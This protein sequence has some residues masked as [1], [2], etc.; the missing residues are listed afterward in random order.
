MLPITH[1]YPDLVQALTNNNMVLLQAPPGAGKSTWLPLQLLRD[2]HFTRIV[3]LEPRRIAARTIANYLASCQ[4][5][6]LGQ[7]IGL[8]IRNEVKVSSE[9]RLEIVSE[10]MLTRMLQG[11]PELRGIDC[12]IFDEYHERSLAADT[13][14]ALARQ[15]QA[16]YRDDLTILLMSAT[17]DAKRIQESFQ[18]P[19]VS[20]D[21]R[22]FPID[23]VYQPLADD[24]RWLEGMPALIKRAVTE[25]GGSCLVFLPGQREIDRIS[26][27]LSGLPENIDIYKLYGNQTKTEQQRAI[28]PS[29]SGRRKIVLATNVAETSLTIEGIRVVVDSGRKRLAKF[30][31]NTGVTEL[32]TVKTSLASSV[33]RAGRAGRTEP[34]VVYRVGS[35]ESFLQRESHDL[36]EILSSDISALLLEAKF[37][38]AELEELEF[39]DRPS[40]AQKNQALD[41]LRMLEAIDEQE[42]LTKLGTEILNFGTDIRWAHMLIKARALEN[43][44]PGICYLSVYLLALLDSRVATKAELSTAIQIQFN[45]PHPIFRQQLSYWFKRLNVSGRGEPKVEYLSLLLA[46]AY[47]DRIAKRR[48]EGYLLA[49]GAGVDAREDYWLNDEF[50][51]IAEL[52]GPKG[53]RIFSGTSIVVSELEEVFPYLFSKKAVCEF[54]ERKGRFIQESRLL[55]GAITVTAKTSQNTLSDTERVSAWLAYIR[56]KGLEVFDELNSHL[57]SAVK[58]ETSQTLNRMILAYTLFPASFPEVSMEYLLTE[59]E[60]WLSPYLVKIKKLDQ[61]KSIGLL[62]PLKNLYDWKQQTE[63]EKLFPSH[64]KVPSGSTIRVSY[65]L[66][67]PAVM[68]VRMQEVYGLTSTPPIANGKVDLLMDLL[69]PARRSLQ[70]TQDLAGFWQSSYKEIQK[71]MKGRYPKHFWPDDPANAKATS[72]VKSKM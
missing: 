1:V 26:N 64:I 5:E 16:I 21:G 6:K 38:G 40:A 11:D 34:G 66:N 68:S 72:K 51:V 13:A 9:T 23:E 20:S 4:K 56:E 17:L 54:D 60:Y 48:G 50:I 41:L 39:L 24:T 36:P 31:L 28:T 29:E 32:C 52:G 70:L 14:L 25:Q 35:K 37:W 10:G 12:I 19:V 47:P 30:N 61:L 42:N 53:K 3:M 22:G 7:S 44:Y 15:S 33:Q 18:C 69:S 59:L 46:L 49:N 8:R 58:C 65:Q 45:H 71:E 43:T 67:G 27:Q 55:L 2:A 62:G 57:S 63:L